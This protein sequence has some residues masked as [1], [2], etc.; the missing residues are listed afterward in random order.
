MV[1]TES[2]LSEIPEEVKPLAH[3][4][5]AHHLDG[6]PGIYR[7]VRARSYEEL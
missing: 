1:S 5:I 4:M 3:I 2:G 7:A 6:Q